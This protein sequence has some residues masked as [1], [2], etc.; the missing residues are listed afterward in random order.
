M[1]N[2]RLSSLFKYQK[3]QFLSL[4]VI[5]LISL[6]APFDF[7]VEGQA[8][9]TSLTNNTS[10][11]STNVKNDKIVLALENLSVERS[12][13]NLVEVR[14]DIKNNS[15]IDLHEIKI[16]AEYFDKDGTSLGKNEHF[17]TMPSQILKP[18]DTTFFDI[19]EIIGFHKLDH[20]SIVASG[21][22][23]K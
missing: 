12:V 22:P 11:S 8:Q 21:S 6:L 2:S 1:R 4:S 17:V 13:T 3:I 18:G 10:T 9:Q 20:Y 14:A 23:I 15:T 7:F 5:P 16:N 19:L